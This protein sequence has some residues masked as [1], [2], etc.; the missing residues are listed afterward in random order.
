MDTL[1]TSSDPSLVLPRSTYH[2]LIH[3]LLAALPPAPGNDPDARAHRNNAAI[4]EVAA[5]LPANADEAAI[6]VQCVASRAYALESLRLA[7]AHQADA[8]FAAPCHARGT[9]LLREARASGSLLLRLQAERRKREAD[10][11]AADQAAWTEHCAI[12]LMTRALAD[13]PPP[14]AEASPPPPE[15]QVPAA[16]DCLPDDLAVEAERYAVI[17]PQRAAQIRALGRLP[18]HVT[19]GP[20]SPEL[21][22]AI[23]TGTTPALRALDPPRAA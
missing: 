9:R 22:H 6:A 17:Y 7:G 11:T 16:D 1:A 18:D 21:V 13:P 15:P 19:F 4:A 14:P 10:T 3:A 23:V 12:G 20:P 5:M 2:H 8:S